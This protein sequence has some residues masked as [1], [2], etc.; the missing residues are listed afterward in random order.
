MGV[1]IADIV[2]TKIVEVN[3]REKRVIVYYANNG[4]NIYFF[5]KKL[6]GKI[7]S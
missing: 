2:V 1:T 3:L 4:T 7:E 6:K 5:K